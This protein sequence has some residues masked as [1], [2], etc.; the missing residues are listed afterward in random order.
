MTSAD[1]SLFAAD[2]LARAQAVIRACTARGWRLATAESCT[3]GLVAALL[4]EIA[5]SSAV[6]DRGFV[7][8]SNDAKVQLLGVLQ[9]TLDRHGAVSPETARE[10]APGAIAHS[11]AD[12]AVSITGIAGPGGGSDGKPVGLVHFGLALRDGTHRHIERRFGAIGRGQVRLA[13]M[14]QALAMIEETLAADPLQPV[15]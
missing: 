1:A 2:D 14:R 5:G 6:F 15:P 9:E 13:S 12:C 4:T 7:T 11:R 3:G 10:M 8:Y